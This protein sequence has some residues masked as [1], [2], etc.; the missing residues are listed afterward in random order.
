MFIKHK[1]YKEIERIVHLYLKEYRMISNREFFKC[2]LDLIKETLD[3]VKE[4]T[5]DDIIKVDNNAEFSRQHVISILSYLE[6][7]NYITIIKK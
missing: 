7:M 1:Y 2:S 4:Y 3:K 5:L 6:K